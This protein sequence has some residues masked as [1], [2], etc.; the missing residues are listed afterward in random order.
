MTKKIRWV[1]AHEPIDLF[2]RAAENFRKEVYDATNGKFD[3]EILSLTDYSQRHND[4]KKVT[5]H[6]LIALMEDGVVEMSQMYTYVLGNYNKDFWALDMPFL[7]GNHDHADAVLEGPIGQGMLSRL[8]DTS[9][10]RGLAFTYSG[11]YKCLPTNVP[12][13]TVE[14]FKNTRIRTSNSPVSQDTFSAVGAEPISI[15]I[16]ELAVAGEGQLVDAGESTYIRILPL[17]QHEVF[18]KVS[19]TEHSLLITSIIIAD[20]FWASLTQDERS[21]IQRAAFTA[22]RTERRESV[23]NAEDIKQY[24]G[25]RNIYMAQDELLKF[26][27]ATAGLYD[28]YRTYFSPGLLDEMLDAGRA[29]KH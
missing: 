5:K 25:E 29:T 21:I 8:A 3:I 17:R 23:E 12:I 24:L 2:L 22:A 15:D 1:I 26:Q 18:A 4:G 16:E 6:D 7:F 10:V 19:C 14:Q 9:R 13:S 11:G 27:K 28:Q 20:S